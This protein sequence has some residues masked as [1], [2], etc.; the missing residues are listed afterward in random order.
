MGD[1]LMKRAI[2]LCLLLFMNLAVYATGP[3][4]I[5]THVQGG[6]SSGV[7]F[8]NAGTCVEQT[9]TSLSLSY[10]PTNTH[11]TLVVSFNGA[12]GSSVSALS[13]GESSSYSQLSV[14][15]GS[16]E[17]GF[18]WGTLGVNGGVT[19]LSAT[20]ST[21]NWSMCVAEYSG[22]IRFGSTP[23]ET[24]F[25]AATSYTTSA[26]STTGTNNIFVSEVGVGGVSTTFTATGGTIRAQANGALSASSALQDVSSATAA[27]V[28]ISGTLSVLHSG[29]FAGIELK[30]Q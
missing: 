28:T 8:V 17:K 2:S 9:G 13:D 14:E 1:T 12:T 7:T 18:L 24:T 16:A 23:L 26:A 22:V 19:T 15:S 11:D 5:A 3:L 27:T 10:T 29:S 4:V 21:G 25:G 30:S 6:G 20:V